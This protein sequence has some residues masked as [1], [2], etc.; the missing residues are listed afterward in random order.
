M[1][2]VYPVKPEIASQ[3]HVGSM[4][5]YERLYRLSLDNPE[6]FWAEQAKACLLYTSD[7]AD[8]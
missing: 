1:S 5:E 7:A 6:W 8:D 3:A 2:D 4:A